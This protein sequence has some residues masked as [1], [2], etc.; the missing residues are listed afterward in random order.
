VAERRFAQPPLFLEPRDTRLCLSRSPIRHIS[1][2]SDYLPSLFID[3]YLSPGNTYSLRFLIT[4]HS[5]M[6]VRRSSR[7]SLKLVDRRSPPVQTLGQRKGLVKSKSRN[8][9][10]KTSKTVVN[11][12]TKSADTARVASCGHS[13]PV[14]PPSLSNKRKIEEPLQLPED[15]QDASNTGHEATVSTPNKRPRPA[16]PRNTN[17]PLQTPGG[18]RIVKSYPTGLF[19]PSLGVAISSPKSSSITTTANLLD[20]ACAH[21]IAVDPRLSPLIEKHHC[22]LFSPAGLQE[23]INPFDSLCSSIISQQVSLPSSPLAFPG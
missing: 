16:N 13:P 1:P 18:S 8:V 22:A 12:D 10:R 20:K 4:S 6:S 7:L 15:S 3:W 5:S 19:Q 2:S 23:T 11:S 9:V 14:S 17:V 21:L